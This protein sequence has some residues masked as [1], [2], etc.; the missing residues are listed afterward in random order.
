MK[1]ARQPFVVAGGL[2]FIVGLIGVLF[3]ELR[4]L[5][6]A[7]TA[8]KVKVV[9][10]AKAE[11]EARSLTTKNRAGQIP[12]HR[13]AIVGD[14]IAG[15]AAARN[16][17][18]PV[19]VYGGKSRWEG[20]LGLPEVWQTDLSVFKSANLE[21]PVVFDSYARGGRILRLAIIA[22]AQEALVKSG[23]EYLRTGPVTLH[24]SPSGAWKLVD[25]DGHVELVTEA[26]VVA[27]GLL[28]P[29]RITDVLAADKS[30]DPR[31]ARL[32]LVAAKMIMSG[33]EYLSIRAAPPGLGQII[34]IIGG[35]GSASDVAIR[36]IRDAGAKEVVIWGGI[37]NDL[38]K[39]IGYI[40][41]I[42]KYGDKI[43]RVEDNVTKVVFVANAIQVSTSVTTPCKSLSSGTAKISPPV[44]LLIESMGRFDF[45]PPEL[46]QQA[47]DGRQIS[48]H[49]VIASNRLIGVRVSF[50]AVGDQPPNPPIYLIGAAASWLPSNVHLPPGDRTAYIDGRN[51]TLKYVNSTAGMENGPPSFAVAAFMG[52]QLA[53]TCLS[54]GVPAPGAPCR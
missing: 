1:V 25:A 19:R 42:K 16:I 33:D 24:S 21:D 48:Y 39:T 31:V 23:A 27:T 5:G 18:V 20:L 13:I 22:V 30:Y 2:V 52:W 17:G 32:D 11:A 37:D 34:G 4:S 49:P 38:D 40:E 3:Y 44:D 41:L 29:K 14:G 35:N 15:A 36:A 53:T 26:L 12:V 28:R 54:K 6:G 8:E 47:A 51:L 43:C 10:D 45:D 9:L 46:I 7:Q 50:D